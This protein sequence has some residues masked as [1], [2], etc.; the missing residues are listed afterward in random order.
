FLDIAEQGAGGSGGT[1]LVVDA[2][3]GK[4]VQLEER[5]QLATAAVGIE[6]PRRA[7]PHAAALAQELR[8]VLLVGD[9][10][11]GRLQPRQLRL[12]RVVAVDLVDHEAAAGQIG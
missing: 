11:L 8:P 1:R 9:Q 5:Q 6:Q 10:Q 12:Q 2:E 7:T 4:V 3:A